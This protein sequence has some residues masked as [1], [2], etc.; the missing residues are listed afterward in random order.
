M[1][2]KSAVQE[3]KIV[4]ETEPPVVEGEEKIAFV[5]VSAD[6][7]IGRVVSVSGAQAVVLMEESQENKAVIP[8]GLMMGTIVKIPMP[9]AVIFGLISALS[10]P[11]P[12]REPGA[13]EMKIMEIEL[14]GESVRTADDSFTPFRRGISGSPAL[15]SAVF[16]TN[17]EDLKL[18]YIRP[19][20]T[21]A[22]IGALHQERRLPALI[23]VDD[24]LGKHFAIVGATGSG[25]SCSV[26]VIL[27]AILEH[28]SN[29]HIILLDPHNEYT[30]AFNER[31][32]IIGSGS[33]HLPYWLFNFEEI[34]EVLTQAGAKLDIGESVLHLERKTA[35]PRPLRREP[36]HHSR[37]TVALSHEPRHAI[38]RRDDGAARQAR[39]L[40]A[41]PS[42]EGR[43][44]PA[45]Q[46][47]ALLVH[48]QHERRDAR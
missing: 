43:H 15:G 39:Q 48:V 21:T 24:L 26:T 46:R 29:G 25:K 23:G 38:H 33:L 30:H 34:C 37:Y 17:T 8:A 36:V 31:A 41:L 5:V 45:V 6:Q 35:V 9:D 16:T 27:R 28:H 22:R 4:A 2:R 47:H 19:S 14:I 1:T 42:P 12:G 11:I 7:R 13:A 44:Q 18:V 3:P 40:G 32:E 10:V 20:V